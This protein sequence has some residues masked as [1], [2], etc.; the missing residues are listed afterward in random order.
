VVLPEAARDERILLAARRAAD[1]GW[2]RPV[3]IGARDEIL[4]LGRRH[5]VDC[6]DLE[7]VDHLR[8]NERERYSE[9]WRSLRSGKEGLD[10]DAALRA[11]ADPLLYGALM[12]R[13]KA[14]DGMTAGAAHP[15]RDVLRAGLRALGTRAGIATVSSVFIMVFTD[16]SVGDGGILVFADCGVVP[17][18]DAQ[19]LADIALSSADTA[20]SLLGLEPRVAMLSFSTRGS[21]ESASVAKVRSALAMAR[22]R[23]PHRR[24]DGELQADAALVATVARRK[25][26]DSDVAGRANVLVFPTLDAGNIGYKLVER[27]AS[28]RAL[29]PILQGLA[30]PVN[31]L[32]RGAAPDDIADVI[33]ITAAQARTEP[34]LAAAGAGA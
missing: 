29:G 33:A 14:A 10:R 21:A 3:L 32:S 7:M 15:T 12:V 16:E 8:H 4:A 13:M 30:A 22:A 27:L 6:G 28:A 23:A 9:A 11:I 2:A 5:G 18:P 1:Q 26:P 20:E 31:D 17:D 34:A 24:I 25:S 19:Q